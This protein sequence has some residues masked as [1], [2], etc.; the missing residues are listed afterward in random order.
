MF[1]KDNTYIHPTYHLRPTVRPLFEYPKVD[2]V[3]AKSSVLYRLVSQL[4][5]V[6]STC[7][8]ILRKIYF[9]SHSYKGFSW[10]V[11]EKFFEKYS[12]TCRLLVCYTCGR[13]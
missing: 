7:P 6:H 2:H 9:K 11:S 1:L 12:Y 13:T 8:D 3:F 10:Y 5:T 4:N